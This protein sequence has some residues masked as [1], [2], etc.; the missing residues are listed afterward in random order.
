MQVVP[1]E[2]SKN[3][4]GTHL[5][6]TV[7]AR[8]LVKEPLEHIP[9]VDA[10]APENPPGMHCMHVVDCGE[11]ENVPALQ[12]WHIEDPA[13][14]LYVPAMHMEQLLEAIVFE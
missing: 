9:Q 13:V 10:L 6:H 14:S 8:E 4:P 12:T 1:L 7:A 5:E 3:H 2:M 11:S